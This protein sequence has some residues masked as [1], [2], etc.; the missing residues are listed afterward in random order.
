MLAPQFWKGFDMTPL[1]GLTSSWPISHKVKISCVFKLHIPL[2]AYP[3]PSLYTAA[4]H[5][6]TPF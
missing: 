6:Q 3:M 2:L 1:T 4:K 5:I